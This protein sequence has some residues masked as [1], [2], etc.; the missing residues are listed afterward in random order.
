M[1]SRQTHILGLEVRGLG[2]DE[3]AAQAG[4]T[5]RTIER[6]IVNARRKLARTLSERGG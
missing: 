6:Q 2:Y 3:I 4:D 5:K 1:S